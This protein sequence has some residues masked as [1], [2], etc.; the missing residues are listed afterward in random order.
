MGQPLKIYMTSFHF[1][2][3]MKDILLLLQEVTLDES[4]NRMVVIRNAMQGDCSGIFRAVGVMLPPTTGG[5]IWQE[6]IHRFA[7]WHFVVPG[8]ISSSQC[9]ELQ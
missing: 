7:E 8:K 6:Q 4:R 9:D 5:M 2:N 3:D 1:Q